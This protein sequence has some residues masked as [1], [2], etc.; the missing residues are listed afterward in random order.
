MD[1]WLGNLKILDSAPDAAWAKKVLFNANKNGGTVEMD[2]QNRIVLPQK[3]R[4]SMQLAE[5]QSLYLYSYRGHVEVLTEAAYLA[6]DE[7][8]AAIAQSAPQSIWDMGGQ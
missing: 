4:E 6:E 1:V 2:P 7:Q 3:M 8:S 5:G